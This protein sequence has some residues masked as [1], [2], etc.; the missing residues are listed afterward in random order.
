MKRCT[1]CLY[2]DMKPDLI[3]EDGVCSACVSFDKRPTVDWDACKRELEAILETG[4]N[5]SGYDCIVASSG[6]K[7]SHFI[8]LTL[9]EM[10]ARPLIVT[11]STCH[12]TG[13][14][15]ENIDNLARYAT[16][17]EV[18]PNRAVRAK[19]NRLGLELVGD[20]SWP[21]HVLIHRVP[22]RVACDLGIPLLFY[23]E[24]P[25]EAYGGPAGTD[26]TREMTQRWV[27]EYGGF[28][29]L[30]TDDLAGQAGISERDLVDYEA[31]SVEMVKK[32]GLK[33]Y[34]LGQ[35]LF[36]DS[37]ENARVAV[38]HGMKQELPTRANWWPAEN[39]D[40]A[41]T[42]LHDHLMYRKYGYGRAVAQLSVD[43]RLGR[44]ERDEA[45]EVTRGR[46]GRFS[47]LYAGVGI[48]KILD[49]IRLTL[50]QLEKILDGFTNWPLFGRRDGLR[51]ILKEFC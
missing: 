1:R 11:A 25:N 4:K 2:P 24:C 48:N 44:I 18:T 29:G 19:L 8:A 31:P 42:G 47:Y 34:F 7:D 12:L 33:A 36:W 9:I 23:G 32:L 22:F 5:D 10:G 27:S 13:I 3:F 26:Q 17:L 20:I 39:L 37:H 40:N 50:P 43:I 41:S 16:T 30:R 15:R 6:G 49:R 28:L 45:L 46:D 14:G 38:A 35:F 21:E 51:P